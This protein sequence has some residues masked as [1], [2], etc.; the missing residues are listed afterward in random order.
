MVELD[1][2][3]ITRAYV[4]YGVIKSI[5]TARRDFCGVAFFASWPAGIICVRRALL[6]VGPDDQI[7]VSQKIH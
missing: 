6:Y 7:S 1:M 5:D 3:D 4:G 2:G